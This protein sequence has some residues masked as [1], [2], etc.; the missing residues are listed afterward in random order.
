MTRNLRRAIWLCVAVILLGVP[1]PRVFSAGSSSRVVKVTLLD[2]T[3]QRIT[4]DGVG[5][6]E[7][8]C[9]RIAVAAKAKGDRRV[10]SIPLDSIA[11]VK[12]ITKDGALF[13]FRDGTTQRLSVIHD[14]QVFYTSNASRAVAKIDLA[15]VQSVEFL[16]SGK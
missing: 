15:H 3:T 2:G 16:G 4:L 5:C 1:M 6:S 9:S 12:D 10:N 8:L 14:N 7:T 13:V 11:A